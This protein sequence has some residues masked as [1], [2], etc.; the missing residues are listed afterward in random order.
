MPERQ[1]ALY[2]TVL[3]LVTT[4]GSHADADRGVIG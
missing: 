1:S 2:F 3:K 4:A